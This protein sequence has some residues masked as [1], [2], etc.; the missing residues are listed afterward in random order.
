[1]DTGGI[2]I[3]P[4]SRME[5]MKHDMT[6][7]ATLFGATL[8]AAKRKLNKRVITVLAFT[9]NMPDGD[10]IT[11]GCVIT[12][13]NGKT[14]EIIN[15]DAEGRLIL[16]DALDYAQ[17]FKPDCM[18]NAATL[19]GAVAVALG[20]Q[21]CGLMTND[22]ELGAK[23]IA[24]GKDTHERM[25]QLPMYDEYFED[26]KTD[27]A[28][29]KNSANDSYGGTIRGG[30]FLKQF[31]R[32]GQSWAHLDIAAMAYGMGHVP[33]YP[34]KGGSGMYVRAVANFIENY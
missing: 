9:E 3:K 21:C 23:L 29:M 15:T 14:V 19:T 28:D 7:A 20:K 24:A 1:M 12:G 32:K 16:A 22:E 17:D 5:D 10:A 33:Y 4:S 13:R 30:I 27:C 8:L 6:G 18:I 2:S 25:W 31:I 34:K 26:L 11:P